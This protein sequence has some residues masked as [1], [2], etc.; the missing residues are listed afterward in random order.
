VQIRHR[1]CE[2]SY[3]V[4]RDGISSALRTLH[5]EISHTVEMIHDDLAVNRICSTIFENVTALKNGGISRCTLVFSAVVHYIS[6][7]IYASHSL[8]LPFSPSLP[9]LPVPLLMDASQTS[10]KRKEQLMALPSVSCSLSSLPQ[11]RCLD[12]VS[13]HPS[14]MS[15]RHAAESEAK[16]CLYVVVCVT[17][18]QPHSPIV[19]KSSLQN[20]AGSLSCRYPTPECPCLPFTPAN[21]EG[22]SGFSFPSAPR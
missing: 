19:E 5:H 21:N 4:Q 8:I 9:L 13:L 16:V 1:R 12:H 22:P 17:I 2:A 3:Y 18:H 15:A 11:A 20:I 10:S 6:S 14:S 7:P